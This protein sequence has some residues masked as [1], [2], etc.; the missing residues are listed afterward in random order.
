LTI[1]LT[2]GSGSEIASVPMGVTLFSASEYGLARS[3]AQSP[4]LLKTLFLLEHLPRAATLCGRELHVLGL[5]I[6]ER[7]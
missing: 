3:R 5:V 7:V 6:F 2:P 1:E 4:S